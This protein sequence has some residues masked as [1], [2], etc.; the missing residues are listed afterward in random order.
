[1]SAT[2]AIAWNDHFQLGYLPMDKTHE[3]FVELM[4]LLVSVEDGEVSRVLDALV[5]HTEGHFAQER[6]WML[7]TEFPGGECHI[8]E[9]AEVLNSMREVRKRVAGGDV[10]I[11]RRLGRE[12]IKWFPAHA[13]YMDSAL[14]QWMERR[15]SGAVPLVFH[16]KPVKAAEA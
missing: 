15:V 14:A 11:A 5:E 4:S 9:H 12:L 16:R 8:D 6:E 1:M 2:S 3:E 7:S 13:D 10:A